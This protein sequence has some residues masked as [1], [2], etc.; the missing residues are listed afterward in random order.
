MNDA[1][2]AAPC[3]S[4]LEQGLATP[5]VRPS[6]DASRSERPLVSVICP[7]FNEEDCIAAFHARLANVLDAQAGYRF[8]ILLVDDGSAD[9]TLAVL[10]S[11]E[12]LDD[13]VRVLSFSRNFGHQIALTAGIE[14]ARGDAAILMD[15]DLQHPPELIPE[16]LAKWSAG[17]DVVSA[18]RRDTVNGTQMKKLS[19]AAFYGVFNFFSKIQVRN[20][21]ADFVLLSRPAYRALQRMPERHRFLRAMTSWIGFNRTYI[22]YTA[23]PRHA[24]QS[25]YSLAKMLLLANDAIFSF[26]VLP[27]RLATRLGLVVVALGALYFCYVLGRA[28]VVGDLVPGWASLICIVLLL[29]GIQLVFLG[30]LGEYLAR[31]YEEVKSRPL[32]LLRD[33]ALHAE[34]SAEPHRRARTAVYQEDAH[35]HS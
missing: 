25:K 16:L 23:P 15:S 33:D 19:S 12:Q 24:G 30:I 28:A 21:A 29:G 4:R 14:H 32:Y 22:D 6:I 11:L 18:V 9:A 26:S 20:G 13:R 27:L 35:A 5:S 10:R 3:G 7:C 34:F 31:V 8:E 17:F 1:A 2:V